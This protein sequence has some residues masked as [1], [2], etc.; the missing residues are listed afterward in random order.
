MD[1]L[2]CYLQH[3]FD[4]LCCLRISRALINAC[5]M[6]LAW[7]LLVVTSAVLATSGSLVIVIVG[8][9]LLSRLLVEVWTRLERYEHPLAKV[10]FRLLAPFR[11]GCWQMRLRWSGLRMQVY[12]L[13]RHTIPRAVYSQ[14]LQ[15]RLT[16]HS[17]RWR[18]SLARIE[19]MLDGYVDPLPVLCRSAC[20]SAVLLSALGLTPLVATAAGVGSAALW[21]VP[22]LALFLEPLWTLHDLLN[23]PG[24]YATIVR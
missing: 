16:M 6:P 20:V 4:G 18:L 12:M 15:L 8:T 11:A 3:Y 17:I 13:V 9:L 5:F 24:P 2:F 19:R 21:A 1:Y 10:L 23:R 7:P 22:L 14:R